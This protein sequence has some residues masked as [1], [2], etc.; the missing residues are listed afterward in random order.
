[1]REGFEDA[2]ACL[3]ESVFVVWGGF[4]GDVGWLTGMTSR[5][6]PSPGRRPILRALL[7]IGGLEGFN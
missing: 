2:A 5:P 7:A 6:M 1:M 4:W 3:G